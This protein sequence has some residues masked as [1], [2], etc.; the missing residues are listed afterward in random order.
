V[1]C[2]FLHSQYDYLLFIDSDVEFEPEAVYRMLIAKKDVVCTPYRLKTV[3]D[4][5]KSKYS[6]TFKDKKQVIVLPGDLVEIEQGPAGIML[7]HRS[8][9]ET[10]MEK[11]PE[12]KINFPDS[13]RKSMNE[14]IMGGQTKEDPVK[15]F[16]Y[17]F[18]D[19]TFNLKTGEWKG[20]DLSFCDLVLKNE[21]KIY[22]NVVST[23]GHYGTYGW[24]G[25]FKDNFK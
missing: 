23:T 13:N 7:I 3:E 24:K 12:L 8:V 10:L 21:F 15:N 18:W 16:M 4:P 19:T 2:G 5:T 22:A 9:F 25:T 11:H 20:E 6:I 14:E 1:T 17:N